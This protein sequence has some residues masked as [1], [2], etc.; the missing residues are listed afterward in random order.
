MQALH[1]DESISQTDKRSQAKSIK[2]DS[3]SKIEAV[4][5]D[6]Q[7]QKFEAMQEKKSEKRRGISGTGET[8]PST[9]PPPDSQPQ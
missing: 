1:Q 7:K 4:L 2:D 3:N 8:S 9:T 5:N 6:D